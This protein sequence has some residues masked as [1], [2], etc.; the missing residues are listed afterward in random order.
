MM[1]LYL[2][3]AMGNHVDDTEE[4]YA[5]LCANVYLS[6]RHRNDDLRGTHQMR[7]VPLP[8]NLKDSKAFLNFTDDRGVRYRD[9]VQKFNMDMPGLTNRLNL[10]STLCS[11]NPIRQWLNEYLSFWSV[12]NLYGPAY[13]DL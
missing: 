10:D 11:F 5:I 2:P 9:L 13:L 8:D 4:F 3:T 7:F 12:S 1:G 6:E